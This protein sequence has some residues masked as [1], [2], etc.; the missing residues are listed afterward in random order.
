[1]KTVIYTQDLNPAVLCEIHTDAAVAE[2]A[3]NGISYSAELETTNV[4]C[5]TCAQLVSAA[6]IA[7]AVASLNE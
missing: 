5:V 7:S 2:L 4:D 1:M 6:A 3:K